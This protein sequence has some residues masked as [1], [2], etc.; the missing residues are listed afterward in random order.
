[1][2]RNNLYNV[3]EGK[4]G[5][6]PITLPGFFQKVDL[7]TNPK[8]YE[9]SLKM[10]YNYDYINNRLGVWF[11]YNGTTENGGINATFTSNL[12]VNGTT[13]YS[14]TKPEN[15]NESWTSPVYYFNCKDDGSYNNLNVT[16]S[17][18]AP[19]YDNSFNYTYK[20]N[21]LFGIYFKINSIWKKVVPKLKIN[22]IWKRCIVWKKINGVWKRG[23]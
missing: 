23:K 22:G 18:A 14:I 5:A 10:Y 8:G 3:T 1:M 11:S 20:L 7:D 15:I 21:S 16:G 17:V 2:R 12:T 9:F 6:S 19:D 4:Y 13:V